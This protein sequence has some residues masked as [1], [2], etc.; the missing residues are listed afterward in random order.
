MLFIPNRLHEW[1]RYRQNIRQL[2][3]HLESC[4]HSVLC[5]TLTQ[6]RILFHIASSKSKMYT[7]PVG[8]YPTKNQTH[9]CMITCIREGPSSNVEITSYYKW[10]S[11]GFLSL[12]RRIKQWNL[13]TGHGSFL[14]NA[15]L[16]TIHN[17]L[18]ISFD[19]VAK[20]LQLKKSRLLK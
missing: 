17:H 16:I 7:V 10:G 18:T 9:W 3:Q 4:K 6:Q 8:S 20:T 11:R 2:L 14:P 12:P 5:S 19:A 15:Y 13:D 1:S